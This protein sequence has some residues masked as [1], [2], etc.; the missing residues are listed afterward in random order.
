[1]KDP[2]DLHLDDPDQ[3]RA[4]WARLRDRAEPALGQAARIALALR[5]GLV[6]IPPALQPPRPA[7][8]DPDATP[9][10]RWVLTPVCPAC[11]MLTGPDPATWSRA[12]GQ[13]APGQGAVLPPVEFVVY[14]NGAFQFWASHAGCSVSAIERGLYPPTT[15]RRL[16]MEAR[17][18]PDGA[19]AP[20]GR[21]DVVSVLADVHIRLFGD[22]TT[23]PPRMVL[24]VLWQMHRPHRGQFY[25]KYLDLIEGL[26]DEHLLPLIGETAPV[27]GMR[28]VDIRAHLRERRRQAEAAAEDAAATWLRDVVPCEEPVEDGAAL[29]DAILEIITRHC[30]LPPGAAAA[31]ALWAVHTYALDIT[32]HTG[33]LGIT[34]PEKRC[35]KSTLLFV[36]EVLSARGLRASH[37]T[38][39]SLFR[40]V[41]RYHPTLLTDEGDAI[42][43]SEEMRTLW[44]ASND[45]DSAYVIRL[46]G[47]DRDEPVQFSTWGAKAIAKIGA[48]PDT[49]DDRSIRIR[50]RRKTER[51]PKVSRLRR[52][53]R[54]ALRAECEPLRRQ[55]Q[56]WVLDHLEALRSADPP[57]VEG[58]NDREADIWDALLRIA[59]VAGGQ[60]P[61]RAREAAR[62]LCQ[63]APD[64]DASTGVLLLDDLRRLF[65]RGEE[66]R[67][68]IEGVT[69]DEILGHLNTMDDRPWKAYNFK[70]RGDDRRMTAEQLA[71]LLR[72]Y[73]ITPTTL[74]KFNLRGYRYDRNL[75]QAWE[76]YLGVDLDL[77][78]LPPPPRTP[79]RVEDMTHK[80][81]PP[82]KTP[83]EP[84]TPQP[85]NE[86]DG[87]EPT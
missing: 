2:S 82:P 38:A 57:E 21:L 74:K 60:W 83:S 77:P 64:H 41:H 24:S 13:P 87:L 29:L 32:A 19:P 20:W 9:E 86:V 43:E 22:P 3:F 35:G 42:F 49:I 8:A 85:S 65:Y 7:S 67:W 25:R 54:E 44:N 5:P 80:R 33:F 52:R 16:A 84:A 73:D 15:H 59:Q 46:V 31:I 69:T 37:L 70:A 26:P 45:R 50:M 30:V 14:P 11:G 62:T 79:V 27:F 28:P 18:V 58:L 68:R 71:R 10:P 4:R 1:V 61:K 34:S 75:L 51:D 12:T 63:V 55:I 23:L 6:A 72:R 81:R 47:E 56:R 66:K 17:P 76:S 53:E 78:P 36:L 40:T 48:L 39:P